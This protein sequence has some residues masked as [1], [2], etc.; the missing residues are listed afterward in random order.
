M[1]KIYYLDAAILSCK[2]M[3]TYAHRYADRA[4]AM[5]AEES[6]PVRRAELETIAEICRHVPEHPPGTSMRRCRPSGSFRWATG[7]RT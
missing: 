2:A 3:I 5:A 1:D 4:E 7:W 6:D